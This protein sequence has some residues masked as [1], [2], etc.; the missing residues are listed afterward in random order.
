MKKIGR[1]ISTNWSG[2]VTSKIEEGSYK[3]DKSREAFERQMKCVKTAPDL[4]KLKGV[5]FQ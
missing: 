2:G 4:T 5:F 3:M 1:K